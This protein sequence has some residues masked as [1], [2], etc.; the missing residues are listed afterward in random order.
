MSSAIE[1]GAP[2]AVQLSFVIFISSSNR[3]VLSDS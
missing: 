2:Q 3:L 1:I